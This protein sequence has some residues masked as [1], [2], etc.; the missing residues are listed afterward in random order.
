MGEI[1]SDYSTHLLQNFYA[2]CTPEWSAC[3]RNRVLDYEE[4]VKAAKKA[5]AEWYRKNIPAALSLP[6]IRCVGVREP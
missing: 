4:I 1:R 2:L 5:E 6:T 3:P